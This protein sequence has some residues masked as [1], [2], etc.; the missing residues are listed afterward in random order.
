MCLFA[1]A[2]TRA[3]NGRGVHARTHT[4][5]YTYTHAHT[6]IHNPHTHI[7]TPEQ[8]R[9]STASRATTS[10][11]SSSTSGPTC[12]LELTP[13]A[14]LFVFFRPHRRLAS[15]CHFQDSRVGAL[16]CGCWLCSAPRCARAAAALHSARGLGLLALHY[17]DLL[18]A[19]LQH[20]W[21]F[22]LL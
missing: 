1:V 16:G 19:F 22:L 10:H 17:R 18:V 2:V 8:T 7:H 20:G 12:A 15:V 3:D 13:A 9:R 11:A 5:T 21:G 6:H 4:H 14:K